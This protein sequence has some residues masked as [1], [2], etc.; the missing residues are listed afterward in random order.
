MAAAV[1]ALPGPLASRRQVE[2]GG[3]SLALNVPSKIGILLLQNW[4][5]YTVEADRARDANWLV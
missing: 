1:L 3:A 2:R 4:F 5:I